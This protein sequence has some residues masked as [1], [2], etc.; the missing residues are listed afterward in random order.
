MTPDEVLAE[1]RSTFP[2][3]VL[4][5]SATA[6]EA[7][8]RAIQDVEPSDLTQR[9]REVITDWRKTTPPPAEM[10]LEARQE[11]GGGGSKADM[12]RENFAW[13]LKHF[14]P[15]EAAIKHLAE[16]RPDD[17]DAARWRGD[18]LAVRVRAWRFLGWNAQPEAMFKRWVEDVMGEG[19]PEQRARR[20]ITRAFQS[21]IAAKELP[22]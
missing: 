14:L 12:I 16:H 17:D 6:Q 22:K 10:L 19:T 18:G 9:W 21:E 13:W 4:A 2:R 20:L 15:I 8:R 11:V 7:Y 5:K 1:I 3:S